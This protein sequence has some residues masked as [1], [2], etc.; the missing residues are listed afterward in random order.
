MA[1]RRM[2]NSPVPGLEPSRKAEV[3]ATG[4][5]HQLGQDE[6]QAGRARPA[7]AHSPFRPGCVKSVP[8]CCK[9]LFSR[10][11][12]YAIF[13]YHIDQVISLI[14]THRTE[15]AKGSSSR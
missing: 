2:G 9:T 4:L 7:R 5:G 10:K 13:T 3:L 14:H 11:T 1:A 6:P 15:N 12:L 8:A